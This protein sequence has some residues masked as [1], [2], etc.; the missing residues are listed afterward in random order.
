[1]PGFRR[2]ILSVLPLNLLY[3]L[4]PYETSEN[5]V[6]LELYIQGLRWFCCSRDSISE[7]DSSHSCTP[8]HTDTFPALTANTAWQDDFLQLFR[9]IN[10][11]FFS[12]S[13]L[14]LGNRH[15][16]FTPFSP[17]L[18]L[19]HPSLPNIRSHSLNNCSKVTDCSYVSFF[20]GT[21]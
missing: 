6:S 9:Y 11:F 4:I 16:L 13:C 7:N 20:C 2:V 17:A 15:H 8:T 21:I 10:D 18:I 19:C 12:V 3:E 1:M 14:S 5:Q